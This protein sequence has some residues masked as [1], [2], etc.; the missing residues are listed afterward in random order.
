LIVNLSRPFQALLQFKQVPREDLYFNQIDS[1][2]RNIM[3]RK[4]LLVVASIS[5]VAL[6]AAGL[7][8]GL[9]AGSANPAA[10][11]AAAAVQGC[12]FPITIT[13]IDLGP[14]KSA[15]GHDVTVSWAPPSNLPNCIA[16]EKYTVTATIKL[17]NRA[18]DKTEVVAGNKTSVT[19][20]VP[21]LP[22]DKDP[23]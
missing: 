22:L 13:N 12:N 16:V 14:R 19:I 5:L 23:Q 8:F 9:P 18:P 10:N 1:K 7:T 20:A 3:I 2:R 11:A 15:G 21:G 17:P 6:I 4:T